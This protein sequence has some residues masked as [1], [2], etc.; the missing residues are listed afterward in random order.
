M[1][2]QLAAFIRRAAAELPPP[3]DEDPVGVFRE[4]ASL[5]ALPLLDLWGARFAIDPFGVIWRIEWSDDPANEPGVVRP[6]SDQTLLN[7]ALFQGSRR[8]PELRPLV[9]G[10]PADARDCPGCRG[11]GV[12]RWW[13]EGTQRASTE[14][15]SGWLRGREP[16]LCLCGGLG[17]LPRGTQTPGIPG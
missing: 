1:S 13:H 5:G 15:M 12:P 11:S 7:M 3:P 2:P 16:P 9:P 6:E 14:D 8:Y 4:T 17:W 10:R